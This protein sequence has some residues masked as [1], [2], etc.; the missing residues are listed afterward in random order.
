MKCPHCENQFQLTWKQYFK[1]C[2]LCRYTC[3]KCQMHFKVTNNLRTIFY[4]I[5]PVIF[6]LIIFGFLSNYI[7][8]F[9]GILIGGIITIS[10]CLLLD[11]YADNNWATTKIIKLIK[12]PFFSRPTIAQYVGILILA[13][14]THVLFGSVQT[15]RWH[16]ILHYYYLPCCLSKIDKK[17]YPTTFPDNYNGKWETWYASGNKQSKVNIINGK[18]EG[19]A[20]AWYESGKKSVTR[21]FKNN[22]RNGKEEGWFENGNRQSLYNYKNGI[23]YGVCKQWHENGAIESIAIV[24]DQFI[25]G[26]TEVWFDNGKRRATTTFIKYN[27]IRKL[28]MWYTN[29]NQRFISFHKNEINKDGSNNEISRTEWNEDGTLKNGEVISKNKDGKIKSKGIYIDG[30]PE[31]EHTYWWRG[32]ID[33]IH[34]YNDGKFISK[35]RIKRKK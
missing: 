6:L 22:K 12:K 4:A 9:K 33:K 23:S 29:G 27:K 19:Q 28:V 13:I 26:K 5:I 20:Y 10:I 25:V 7:R 21:N 14:F 3:L 35:K 32:K 17:N 2:M 24:K 16:Y 8:E 34:T 31:G 15:T 11:K 18:R 30:K 1:S